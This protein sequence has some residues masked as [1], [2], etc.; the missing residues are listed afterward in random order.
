MEHN[1][2]AAV[3][4]LRATEESHAPTV[5]VA[6]VEALAGSNAE[7]HLQQLASFGCKGM[8]KVLSAYQNLAET[9]AAFGRENGMSDDHEFVQGYLQTA[10]TMADKIEDWKRKT[11]IKHEL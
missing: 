2:Q 3:A 7:A 11:A 4:R 1:I 5:I 10:R 6:A 8:E 9:C